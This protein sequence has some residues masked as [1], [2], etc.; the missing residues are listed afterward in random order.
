MLRKQH[1]LFPILLSPSLPSLLSHLLCA[2]ALICMTQSRY[3]SW[4]ADNALCCAMANVVYGYIAIAELFH[5]LIYF[6]SLL[7]IQLLCIQLY[8][9]HIRLYFILSVSGVV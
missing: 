8:A 6:Y 2:I 3:D 5:F 7:V 9:L 1:S 4:I